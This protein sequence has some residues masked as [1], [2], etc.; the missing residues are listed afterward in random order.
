MQY[1]L[2]EWPE[3]V[4]YLDSPYLSPDNNS[5]E[6]AIRTFVVGRKNWLFSEKSKGVESSCAMHSLLETAQ[7]NNA[8]P[9]VY[10]RAIFEMA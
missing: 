4:Q 1:T 8:N 7:Q 2:N 5:A 6:L 10:V 3:L 9:N